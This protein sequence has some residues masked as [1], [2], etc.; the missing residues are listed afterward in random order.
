MDK[1]SI[2]NQHHATHKVED[3]TH[4]FGAKWFIFFLNPA[5]Q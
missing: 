2:L 4:N 5:H 3:E 1:S